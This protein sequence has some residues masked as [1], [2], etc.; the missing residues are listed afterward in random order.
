MVSTFYV[1]RSSGEAGSDE[2]VMQNILRMRKNDSTCTVQSCL[3][4]SNQPIVTFDYY[5]LLIYSLELKLPLLSQ[6]S[7]QNRI[8][9]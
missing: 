9:S 4:S 6:I 7:S 1:L 8:L 3:S 2:L 5:L